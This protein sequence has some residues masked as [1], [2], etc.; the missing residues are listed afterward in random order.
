MFPQVIDTFN[1]QPKPSVKAK[2]QYLFA[3]EHSKLLHFSPLF[4]PPQTSQL[5]QPG[6]SESNPMYFTS[7][8]N[9]HENTTKLTLL[10]RICLRIAL[11]GGFGWYLYY[12]APKGGGGMSSMLDGKKQINVAEM[13]SVRFS[14]VQ[15]I[16]EC[17]VELQDLVAF[18]KNPRKFV[19]KGAKLPKGVLLTGEPGTGKT[20]LAKA[21]AGEAGVKFFYA[22]GS[23]FEEVF[24]GL[25]ARRVREL[26][27]E[28]KN[29]APCIVFIDEIDALGGSR[30]SRDINFN[31]QSLN[32]L[33][34]ELDGFKSSDN[35]V[36]IGATNLPQNL[37]TALKRSGRFDKEINIPLP[38]IKGRE[39]IFKLYISKVS[40]DPSV[41]VGDMARMTF[42]NTGADIANLVNMAVLNSV[43]EGRDAFT[44]EDFE[45][46]I[47][48]TLMGVDRRSLVVTDEE[49]MNTAL[50]EIGHVLTTL[51]T[52]GANRL[53]KVNILPRGNALGVTI[54]VLEKDYHFTSMQELLARVD[55][56]MGGR[57]AEELFTG[58]ENLTTGCGGD[59]TSA[60]QNTYY[61]VSS[62]MFSDLTGIVFASSLEEEGQTQRDLIDKSVE[63]VLKESRLRVMKLLKDNSGLCLYLAKHLKEKESLSAEQVLQ[64]V[65]DYN[66]W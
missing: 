19:E 34:V 56:S 55:V 24:V 36:V 33:L 35:V 52:K 4:S 54:S 9:A 7:S 63:Q 12:Y 18:L 51:L 23:D 2:Q 53:Y 15:G 26:F 65:E 48:R 5:Q 30:A 37:D 60:I 38:D 27:A 59:M 11:I 43:K 29:Q 20:L 45:L 41:D 8:K 49:K 31:R 28:A 62:G 14:D 61:A 17:K 58:R 40:H 57:C 6:S 50:H 64:L 32:Q 47:E 39:D 22:S 13:S 1:S 10:F 21:I 16:D 42:G 44:M 3:L 25:G 66:R 46:A